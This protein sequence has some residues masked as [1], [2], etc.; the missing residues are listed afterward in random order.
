MIQLAQGERGGEMGRLPAGR[1]GCFRYSG[2]LG[3]IDF[4]FLVELFW[5][6]AKTDSFLQLSVIRYGVNLPFYP[7]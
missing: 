6:G 3:L 2:V 7:S 4:H 5:S 1:L